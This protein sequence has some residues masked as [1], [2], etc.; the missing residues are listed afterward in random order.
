MFI[1]LIQNKEVVQSSLLEL[2]EL[3]ANLA[4]EEWVELERIASVLSIFK[5]ATELICHASIPTISL[6]IV[7]IERY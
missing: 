7:L 6:I 1:R 3:G 5:E 2:D 4:K